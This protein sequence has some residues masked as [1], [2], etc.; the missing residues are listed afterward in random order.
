LYWVHGKPK[1]LV[2]NIR[3]NKLD[4]LEKKK[5]SVFMSNTA[6]MCMLEKLK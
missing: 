2:S 1:M 5:A 4:I 6:Q 3:I